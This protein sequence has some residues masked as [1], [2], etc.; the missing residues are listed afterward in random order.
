MLF[1]SPA[2]QGD[3]GVSDGWS[4][5]VREGVLKELLDRYKF[6]A[7]R[8]AGPACGSLLDAVVPPLP[9]DV[10]VVP[11][12]TSPAHRRVR[13][14]DHM[15]DVT[16]SF[17]R[18]R[19]LKSRRLFVR[20][21]SDTQHFKNKAERLAYTGQDL[22]LIGGVPSTVLLVDDIYTTGATLGACVRILREAGANQVF[23]AIIARQTLDD[24][25]DL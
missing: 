13:G 19:S 24:M 11:A 16:R 10:V 1:R 7:V 23:V 6:D 21:S 4:V 12:P 8:E 20:K 2:C 18:R 25:S 17:A 3:L 14:F 22:K 15:Y 9:P 5:G